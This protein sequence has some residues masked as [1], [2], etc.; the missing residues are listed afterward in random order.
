MSTNVIDMHVAELQE[1][2]RKL[3][4]MLDV[5]REERD[6]ALEE[7]DHLRGDLETAKGELKACRIEV[8]QW[9]KA[10]AAAGNL[11]KLAEPYIY[12]DSKVGIY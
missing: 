6:T 3:Q 9:H 5:V 8:Q 1:Q 2:C 4:D 11:L 10:A 12:V 7:Q